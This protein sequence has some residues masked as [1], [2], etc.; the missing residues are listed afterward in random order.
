MLIR[1][2]KTS[3]STCLM[4]LFCLQAF[5]AQAADQNNNA[6]LGQ[7]ELLANPQEIRD[8]FTPSG[9]MFD[10]VGKQANATGIDAY[11]F[12]RSPNSAAIPKM[13]LRG[14]VTQ[15]ENDPVALLEVAGVRTFL[16]RE[17]DEINIDPSQP[18]SAIRITKIT[19]LSVTVETGTL[20]SIRVQ[21]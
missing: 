10:V 17:G 2:S 9:L 4:W 15:D 13:R 6:Y 21:R 7:R 14:F 19:R 18:N 11:G 12:M 8:P 1:V 16:V 5:T 20:G 3:F